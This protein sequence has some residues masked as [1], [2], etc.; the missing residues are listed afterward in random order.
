MR[1]NRAWIRYTLALVAS[2]TLAANAS[3]VVEVPS[4]SGVRFEWTP[5]EGSV[6]GYAIYRYNP[7][8]TTQVYAT[9]LSMEPWTVIYGT[10]GNEYRIR[11]MAISESS[12]F[13]PLSD[14]SE[15]VRFVAAE[16]PPA[17]EPPAEE[18]PAEEP[19]AEEPPAEEPPAEEPP[20]EE[21]PSGAPPPLAN[22]AA[23]EPLDFDGDGG[24]EVL[25]R[26]ET[27]GELAI[28]YVDGATPVVVPLDVDPL[29]TSERV[30][31]NADYD[32]NGSAD[33][34]VHDKKKGTLRV[35]FLDTGAQVGMLAFT[36][37]YAKVVGS[38][39]FDGDGAADL[40][41]H[42]STNHIEVWPRLY[43][44]NS[45]EVVELTR[46]SKG[47][48]V[49]GIGDMDGDSSPDLLF[50]WKS[51]LIGARIVGGNLGGAQFLHEGGDPRV[52][53]LCRLNGGAAVSA[54]I[55]AS[56]R[57]RAVDLRGTS[58]DIPAALQQIPDDEILDGGQFSGNGRCDLL[59]RWRGT[60]ELASG[61]I[62]QNR[63]E[64][65]SLGIPAPGWTP[66]GVRY[67]SP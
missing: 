9:R 11:V 14:L 40:V 27:S 39:D 1:L 13:G 32:G 15:S 3:A 38:G 52:A 64:T 7:A 36:G 23:S 51:S 55:Y 17:E 2:L 31:G 6:A 43:R 60:G 46:L 12:E 57:Y 21:P 35:H 25:L 28:W 48:E 42:D 54:L 62:S 30:V 34:A 63:L 66:V 53:A 5:A 65:R 47:T 49:V 29:A 45:D 33:V 37:A 8:G 19:P 44:A 61:D 22:R 59:F 26:H 56:G 4:G 41:F 24:T 20:T 67:R 50:S 10:A 58:T 18:P 16:A